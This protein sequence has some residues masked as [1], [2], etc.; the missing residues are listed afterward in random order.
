[1][2]A[3]STPA[4]GGPHVAVCLDKSRV[5]GAGVLQGLADYMEVHGPWSVFLEPFGNGT[6]P[7]QRLDRWSGQGI[8]ALLCSEH[9]ARRAAQLRIPIVDLCGNMP[10]SDL[11]KLGIPCVTSDHR[12]IGQLGA[13]HLLETGYPHFAFSGYRLLTWVE[14][15]W[16]GFSQTVGAA[17]SSRNEYTL[18]PARIGESTRS[19]QRWAEAQQRLTK[20]IDQ[21][22]KPVGIMA[23]NDAHALDLLDACRRAG[24]EVPD[25]VAIVGVDNDEALCRL[26][27]PELSS[28]VPDP[29]G[30]GYEAAR[31]LDDLMS[32]RRTKHDAPRILISPLDV[33]ARLSTQGTAVAD[34]VIARALRS[35]RE[36]APQGINA[37]EILRETGLS[38]R[39]FYQRFQSLVGRTPHKEISRVRVARV[40]RLLQETNL[41]LEKVAELTGYCSAAHM[42]VSFRREIGVPPGE[43]R[44]R[45]ARPT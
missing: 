31:M 36:R 39:A 11:S 9:S 25:A 38:R 44:R 14:E 26:T 16:Q 3:G 32:G 35:I 22:P 34:E 45:A 5:Y 23:C 17:K 10:H 1:M 21:L 2:L 4:Q 7:W 30:V 33:V 28:V 20:W 19:L 41:S 43:F 12:A 24:L 8:L 27:K 15:R 13:E 42:S 18:P 29:R 40:K 6:L 37:E